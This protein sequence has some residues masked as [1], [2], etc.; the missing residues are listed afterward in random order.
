MKFGP[1][2]PGNI[3]I[4]LLIYALVGSVKND[5]PGKGR[6]LRAA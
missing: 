4:L 2:R 1:C 6:D 3:K 5:Y